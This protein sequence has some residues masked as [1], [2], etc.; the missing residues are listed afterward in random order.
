MLT[1]LVIAV[2][3]L[4]AGVLIAAARKPDIFEV[5]RSATIRATPERIFALLADFQE[6]GAWSPYE[7][8]D[9]A[10]KR[11]FKGATSGVG[12]V[13]AFDGNKQVGTGELAIIEVQA[14]KKLAVT[15][16]M[17]RPMACSNL[18]TFTLAPSEGGTLVTWHM[19]GACP[20]MGKL[21]GTIF[22]MDRMV[23]GDFDKGLADLKQ[24]A[25]RPK[26]VAAAA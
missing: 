5:S 23:G 8:K 6:W 2:L 20:F 13:Y 26:L 7:K 17:T 10:M 22:N 1:Y 15:L 9:P 24:A 11:S 3:A 19:Q 25:E 21:M 4:V 18:I 16:D 14:P 12:A